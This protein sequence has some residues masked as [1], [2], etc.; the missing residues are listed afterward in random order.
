MHVKIRAKEG[1]FYMVFVLLRL[2]L[3]RLSAR[4]GRLRSGVTESYEGDV[5]GYDT[6]FRFHM[7]EESFSRCRTSRMTIGAVKSLRSVWSA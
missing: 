7:V 2:W 4:C 3:W 1:S 6:R 5:F